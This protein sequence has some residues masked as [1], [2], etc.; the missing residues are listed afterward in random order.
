M[1]WHRNLDCYL[2]TA[3]KMASDSLGPQDVVFPIKN[4]DTLLLQ[5]PDLTNKKFEKKI[6][7]QNHKATECLWLTGYKMTWIQPHA[8]SMCINGSQANEQ[9]IDITFFVEMVN[10]LSQ[11]NEYHWHTARH[12]ATNRGYARGCHHYHDIHTVISEA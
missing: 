4:W 2:D 12:W 8:V 10:N 7:S 1:N 6:T 11:S 5:S 3:S 9:Q